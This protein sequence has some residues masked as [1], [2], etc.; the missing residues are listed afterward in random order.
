MRMVHSNMCC[1]CRS[2]M[3]NAVHLFFDSIYTASVREIMILLNAHTMVLTSDFN[4]E[5]YENT[6]L[7]VGGAKN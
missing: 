3:E 2:S 6:I 1:M 4:Q 5:Q 7:N